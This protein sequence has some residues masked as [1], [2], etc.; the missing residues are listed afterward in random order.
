MARLLGVCALLGVVIALGFVGFE[1]A[2]HHGQHYLW[3]TL[4]GRHPSNIVVIGLATAGGLALGLAL[5][6]VPG[7]GGQHPGDGHDPL[8]GGGDAH[9]PAV[10]GSLVVGFVG[11]VGGASLGPEGAVLPV[12]A[13]ISVLAGRSLRVSQSMSPLVKAA[14]LGALLAAMF[15][16]PLAGVVPLMEL[17]PAGAVPTMAMLLLPSLTAAATAVLTLQVLGTEPIG[18]LPL[19]YGQ[20]HAI[21]LLW[22]VIIGVVAGAVGLAID[23]I[24]TS[25][26]R[27]TRRLDARSVVLTATVGGL[28]LGVLYVIGG[29]E[30]RFSGIPELL[31]LIQRTDRAWPALLAVG[32]KLLATGW[33]L[34]VGYRGGKIFPVVFAGGA[35]GLAVHLAFHSIPMPLA[36]AVGLAAAMATAMGTPATA[37]LITA[38][39]LSPALL[40]L[41]LIGIVTAH[42]VHLLADQLAP[43]AVAATER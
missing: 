22:A 40:P 7:H 35:T 15:G 24:T 43:P 38:S 31:A 36:V 6:F 37:A 3:V 32:V 39:L 4:A 11:L 12:A 19:D 5:R 21:H 20:F 1:Q 34:A 17:I 18:R 25:L 42:S 8:A 30:V 29:P 27:G 9:V 10:L 23:R 26:R 14:G 41:A 2:L 33:C 16:S 13:G 28:V